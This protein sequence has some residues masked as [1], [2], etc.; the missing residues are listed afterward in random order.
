VNLDNVTEQTDILVKQMDG[1][2][3]KQA[4]L[5]PME[6]WISTDTYMQS[7]AIYPDRLMSACSVAPRPIELAREKIREYA[8]SGCRALVLDDRSYHSSDPAALSLVEE[9]VDNQLAMFLHHHEMTIDTITFIDRISQ[10]HEDGK[11][12]VLHMGSLFGF[13]NLIPLMHREN[14]WLETSVTLI[15]LVESPLRG[16]LDALV[17]D[18]G[19]RRL[20][21]GSDHFT[22]YSDLMAALN[23]MN[24]NI[25]TSKIIRETNAKHILNL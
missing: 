5:T 22:D 20:V 15:K 7:A 4:V 18:V 9:A 1:F 21:F 13:H 19:V 6:P 12:V 23:M 25:E 17:Q 24:L 2:G 16:F 14:I 11:F 8:E 10:I 3:I